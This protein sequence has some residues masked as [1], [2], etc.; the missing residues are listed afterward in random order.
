LVSSS[1]QFDRQALAAS[2]A[3]ELGGDS[4]TVLGEAGYSEEDVLNMRIS[5][6]LF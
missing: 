3:P 2:P 5:G 1:V 6:I 4:D